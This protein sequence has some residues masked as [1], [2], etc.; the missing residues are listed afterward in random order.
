MF[1]RKASLPFLSEFQET[2]G[3]RL[4]FVSKKVGFPNLFQNLFWDKSLKLIFEIE[5]KSFS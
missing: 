3:W 5:E 1:Y 4:I 2:N